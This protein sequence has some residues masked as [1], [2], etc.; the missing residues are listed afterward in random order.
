MPRYR[1]PLAIKVGRKING[2]GLGSEL[3]QLTDDFFLTREYLITCRPVIIRVNTHAPDKLLLRILFLVSR[4]LLR[5][6]LPRTGSL[7]SPR[8]G[9]SLIDVIAGSRQIPDVANA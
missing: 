1:L 6:H 8:F 5:C 9:V 3:C 4:F 7:R 2:I